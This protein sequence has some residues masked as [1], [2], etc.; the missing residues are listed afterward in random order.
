MGNLVLFGESGSIWEKVVVFGKK[1][2]V[3]GQSGSIWAKWLYLIPLVRLTSV[4]LVC[5]VSFLF[6]LKV[7]KHF[8]FET[9]QTLND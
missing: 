9:L 4:D 8:S 7:Y 6:C 2:V 3:F 5:I 1:L